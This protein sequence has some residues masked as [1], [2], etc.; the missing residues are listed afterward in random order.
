MLGGIIA[1][2]CGTQTIKVKGGT[3][4]R[5]IAE[6]GITA[7]INIRFDLNMCREFSTEESQRKC[8]DA[9]IEISALFEDLKA[10][11]GETK[12]PATTL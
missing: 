10:Q 9:L 3:T 11:E 2:A 8:L 6:G 7:D 5:F 4:N 1:I 12:V